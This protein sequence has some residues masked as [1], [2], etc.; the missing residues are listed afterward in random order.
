MACVITLDGKKYDEAGFKQL[1]ASG[2]LVDEINSGVLKDS[3]SEIYKQYINGNGTTEVS[4]G[5]AQQTTAQAQE[6][7]GTGTEA[8]Q[9]TAGTETGN[10]IPGFDSLTAE[11]QAD[12]NSSLDSINENLDKKISAREAFNKLMSYIGEENIPYIVD[13]KKAIEVSMDESKVSNML[14]SL[15]KAGKSQIKG[16]FARSRVGQ[17][18]SNLKS[19]MKSLGFDIAVLSDED[20]DNFVKDAYGLSAQGQNAFYAWGAKTMV[21][22]QSNSHQIALHEFVHPLLAIIEQ[23]NKAVYDSLVAEV[24]GLDGSSKAAPIDGASLHPTGVTFAEWAQQNYDRGTMETLDNEMLTELISVLA[25]KRIKISSPLAQAANRIWSRIMEFFGIKG[26]SINLTIDDTL[27]VSKIARAISDA[28]IKAR[29]IKV[30]NAAG[31]EV[32]AERGISSS[33]NKN[34]IFDAGLNKYMTED[35]DGNYVFYH[36]SILDLTKKGIDP[37]KLGSNRRTGRDETMAK[38][39]VSM[40]YTEP[41]IAD[42]SGEY[43]HVVMIPKEKVYPADQDPLNLRP[44]A[45]KEF[46]KTFP[47]IAFDN[48]RAVSWIGKVAADKGY[49]MVVASW[50]PRRNFKA[51]RAESIIKQKP[52]L[53][54]KPSGGLGYGITVDE[55]YDFVSNR[56]RKG[57]SSS[58]SKEVTVEPDTEQKKIVIDAKSL[59]TKERAGSRVGKGLAI[60]KGTKE[61]IDKL[62]VATVRELAPEVFIKNA[63]IIKDYPLVVGVKKM[64]E[65]TNV[66]EAQVIYDVFV[67]QVVDNLMFLM[68]NFNEKFKNIATLWYDGANVFANEFAN[69]YG[70]T[71]EQASGIIAAMSPQK[72]WYQNVRLAELVLEA[73]TENPVFTEEMLKK[74]EE[75]NE[76]GLKEIRKDVAKGKKTQANLDLAIEQKKKIMANLSKYIGSDLNSIPEN[77]KPYIVRLSSEILKSKDYP[78]LSPDGQVLEPATKKD[79]TKKK[80]AWGSYTEIGKAVYIYLNPSQQDISFAL[81]EMHKI[82]N[83]YNNII[84]PMSLDGDV[85]IDTHAVAAALFLPLSGKTKEV[86][87]N[88]GSGHGVSSSAAK[89]VKGLYYAYA[90]AYNKVAEKTGLLPR[91]VQS[92]TWEAVRGLYTDSF[93][94]TENVKAIRAIFDNYAKGKIT[95]DEARKQSIERAGGIDD[96]TWGRFISSESIT[97]V[98]RGTAGEGRG[99]SGPVPVGDTGQRGGRGVKPK[100]GISS[101][102]SKPA[103]GLKPKFA[104]SAKLF[105]EIQEA[106]GAAKKRRLAEERRTLIEASP[107]VKFID[108]N[109]KNIYEQLENKG[110]LTREGNC[111]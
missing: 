14:R 45:E 57:L 92:I 74:Q 39:P 107:E 2:F 69:K 105:D 71:P 103:P 82:R 41:D 72:D 23:S 106:D 83:F 93:K 56:K 48:N 35:G 52:K 54:E 104:E 59:K 87:Q 91:Q 4:G 29:S 36:R 11:Q 51:L 7:Q 44:L 96:P 33:K 110:V 38:Y 60:S 24:R 16:K 76:A 21:L 63:N 46:R 34:L 5:E 25:D 10:Q 3:K 85:T 66:K 27:T 47:N 70:V 50:S 109:I 13:M 32:V 111:P 55:K 80:V 75:V 37:N 64:K 99:V 65:A 73:M 20:F 8:G 6:A 101:S 58:R 53:Y 28:A 79:G 42:V 12:F 19:A 108:D 26:A 89:G 77:F 62:D 84:D 9:A 15:A 78:V 88:F 68:D 31:V 22:R 90:D 30:M 97:D 94:T 40:Y 1:L 49:E 102:R 61:E 67:N 95:L 18:L 100:K 81:G 17:T 43:T 86:N 98:G